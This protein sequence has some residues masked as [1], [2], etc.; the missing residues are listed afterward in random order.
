MAE[1]LRIYG[2][3]RL[4]GTVVVNGGKNAALAII[5]AALLCNEPCTIENLPQVSDTFA[6]ESILRE[7]GAKVELN[8][9]TMTIDP[10]GVNSTFVPEAHARRL[11]AS[12]YFVGTLLACFGKAKVSYPGGCTIGNRPI[13]QH[14]KGFEALGAKVSTDRGM[15]SAEAPD[16]LHGAE[17][18][19]DMPSVGATINIMLA[20]TKAQ[21]NTTIVNAGKEPHIVDLANFINAMGGSVKGAGTDTIRIR[22]GRPMHGC[23][24][25]VIP[26]QIETGTLMIAAAATRGDVLIRGALPT[27]MEALTAKLLEMGAHVDEGIGED[28]IRVRSDGNHRHVN[29]KTLPYPGFPTDLQQPMSVLLST[30]RGTSIINETI[31]E[32]RFKHL[33]EIRRMGGISQINDRIAII[34]G[35]PKLVGCPVTATDL[36]AGAALVIAGLMAE[37]VTDIYNV[38]FIDRGYE[39][40][41]DKL[42][43]LGAQIERLPAE[44]G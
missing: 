2:G 28:S 29:I 37:G 5:P 8:G 39:H 36:R 3:H 30:A 4:E 34:E 12:Y 33:E 41:E 38:H 25:A 7:L 16:G 6:L 13:D 14:I 32:M 43:S 27:H 26:D 42:R 18:Y 22:G 10:R 17:L 31:F 15:I 9:S 20:A 23:T 40:L 21:G 35:V 44:E 24:Y 1:K 19:L 11:R